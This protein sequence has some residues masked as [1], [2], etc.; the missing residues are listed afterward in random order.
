MSA[1][2]TQPP[3]NDVRR[4]RDG[5][6]PALERLLTRHIDRVRRQISRQIGPQ[7]QSLLSAD[8]VTQQTGIDAFLQ[9]KSLRADDEEG[10]AAWLERLARNNLIDAIRRLDADK[11]PPLDRRLAPAGTETTHSLVD[12]IFGVESQTPSRVLASREMQQRLEAAV[13]RLP[14]DYQQAIRLLDLQGRSA[15]EV[16]EIMGRSAGAVHMIRA[17]AHA[18]LRRIFLGNS[19]DSAFGA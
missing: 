18:L 8:D 17:R 19:E 13:G 1:A 5:D 14:P 10:F 11:R 2:Q 4:A 7:Y 9:V 15:V 12:A 3:D 16:A 6:E